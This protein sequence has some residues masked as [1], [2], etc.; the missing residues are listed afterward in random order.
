MSKKVRFA[1]VGLGHI[2][3]NA[4]LPAFKHSKENCELTGF[5]SG[6]SEKTAQLGSEYGV[7]RSWHYDDYEDALAS[8]A[9]D[10]VYIALPDDMHAEYAV[11]AANHGIHVLCEKPMATRVDECQAMIDAAKRN[12][13]KLMIAY[14]LHF[15]RTNMEAL[16]QIRQGKIGNPR[17]FNAS[18]GQQIRAGN[19]RTKEEHSG[20]P[21]HD[22]GIYC[23]NAARYIFGEEPYEVMGM[24]CAANDSRFAEVPETVSAMLKFPGDR[25]ASFICSFGTTDDISRFEVAGTKGLISVDPA[26]G[27]QGEL[28]YKLTVGGKESLHKTPKRDQ[29]A[30]ELIHF[31]DCILQNKEPNPCGFEGQKDV[32]IIAAIEESI[33]RGEKVL[34]EAL[35]GT[36]RPD[37]TLIR[38]KP[39]VKN[40]KLVNVQAPSL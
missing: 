10:A 22:I 21:L 18:F 26:F 4:V 36:V 39:A 1:V 38:E 27:Y 24:A 23:L 3:Q 12:N 13:I 30:P 5:V 31:A 17:F 35:P 8:K 33:R 34:L 25:I 20:G 14:R 16:E 6:D 11:K 28:S 9:F 15:E 7:G 32:R 37:K 2:A 29:F 40:P 19:I